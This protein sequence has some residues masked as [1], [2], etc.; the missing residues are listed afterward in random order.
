MM[1]DILWAKMLHKRVIIEHFTSYLGLSEVYS[2]YP[3]WL[4]QLAYRLADSVI[5]HTQTLA[6]E[7]QEYLSL[8]SG[9]VVP[10]YCQV[11]L[12][13]FAPRYNDETARLRRVLGIGDR[14]VVFY[15]GMHHVWHGLEYL[16]EAA[17]R[18][19]QLRN[20]ILFVILPPGKLQLEQIGRNLIGI[21]EQPFEAL[22]PYIQLADVWCSGFVEHPRGE[23]S[24]SST[25]I[26]ALAMGR[27]VITSPSPEKRRF[28]RDGETAFFVPP[29][30]A[31]AIAEKILFCADHREIVKNNC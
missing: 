17:K 15:H 2:L 19:E 18:I 9:K 29:R 22:P 28:L 8:P 11:D 3:R 14:F 26:Q 16:L 27:L 1:L 5:C 30:N 4:D 25:L 23:R 7:M 6:D 13:L 21:P 10:L 31:Q 24:L 12:N 20:D